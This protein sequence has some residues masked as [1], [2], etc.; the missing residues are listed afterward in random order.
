MTMTMTEQQA[1]NIL[2]RSHCAHL[3]PGTEWAA[4]VVKAYA[5]FEEQGKTV[6][7]RGRSGGDQPSSMV[8]VGGSQVA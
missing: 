7:V 8:F 4:T 1:I 3:V 6:T 5:F 2:A